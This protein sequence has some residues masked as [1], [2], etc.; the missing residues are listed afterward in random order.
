MWASSCGCPHPQRGIRDSV[1]VFGRLGGPQTQDEDSY[2]VH[3]PYMLGDSE[4]CISVPSSPSVPGNLDANPEEFLTQAGMAE[5]G[6]SF[7]PRC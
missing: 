7:T 2:L 4:P 6:P 3:I 1:P 5:A